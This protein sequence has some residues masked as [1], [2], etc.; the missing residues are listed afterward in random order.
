[1][2]HLCFVWKRVFGMC[3]KNNNKNKNNKNKNNNFST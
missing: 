2:R 1:M 3:H